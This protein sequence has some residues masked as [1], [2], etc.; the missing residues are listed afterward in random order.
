MDTCLNYPQQSEERDP[1][2]SA[3]AGQFGA[4]VRVCMTVIVGEDSI[5]GLY[6]PRGLKIF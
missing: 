3:R 5:Q 1:E 2:F 6:S 4:L